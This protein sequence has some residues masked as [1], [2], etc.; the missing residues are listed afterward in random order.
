MEGG[1]E[2]WIEMMMD[3]E[4]KEEGFYLAMEVVRKG[5]GEGEEGRR[6]RLD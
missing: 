3:E 1:R 4:D 2:D 6:I 5:G